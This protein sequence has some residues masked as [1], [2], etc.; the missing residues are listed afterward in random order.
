MRESQLQA[1]ESYSSYELA[2]LILGTLSTGIE[3]LTLFLTVLFAYFAVAYLVGKKL[4][5]FQLYSI[6]FVYSAFQLVA[7][8]TFMSLQQ[9]LE[10]LL[11]F[12]DGETPISWVIPSSVCIV[13]WLLSIV[14]MVHSRKSNDT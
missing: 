3:Q 5:K 13:G 7:V 1:L 11:V 2:E 12:R 6:T 8:V 10:V 9:R 4:T 14:F